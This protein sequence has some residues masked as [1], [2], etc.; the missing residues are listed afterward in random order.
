MIA[1][2]SDSMPVTFE[3]AEKLPIKRG[4]VGVALEL[5]FQAV[6]VD[7]AVRVL[8]DHDHVGD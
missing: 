4:R 2:V 3:A 6:E 8:L 7:L 5:G 1:R